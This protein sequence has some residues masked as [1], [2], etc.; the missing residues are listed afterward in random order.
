[1]ACL[2]LPAN[3]VLPIP[4][5][6]GDAHASGDCS[7]LRELVGRLQAE[8]DAANTGGPGQNNDDIRRITQNLRSAQQ[9]LAECEA[10]CPLPL[11]LM[12]FGFGVAATTAGGG[13]AIIPEPA[14]TTLGLLGVYYGG[15]AL[16]WSGMCLY[17]A[18]LR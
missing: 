14:S 12:G 3:P 16:I 5:V 2:I 15:H 9:G 6:G 4:T 11:A 7:G 1:M 10:S 18:Y 17:W 8:L 13:A